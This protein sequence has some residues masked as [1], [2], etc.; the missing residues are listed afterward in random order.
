MSGAPGERGR[1]RE[2]EALATLRTR[3]LRV[4]DRNWRCRWGELD[5]VMD[6]GG[7]V[8]FVEVRYRRSAVYGGAAESIG[9]AKIA[10]LR[11]AAEAWLQAHPAWR[12]APVRFDVMA[13]DGRPVRWRWL[14]NAF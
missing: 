5:L 4:L 2:S 1:I 12:A 10:R 13:G 14:R 7:T 9:A 8:V 11:R 6:E 3:G